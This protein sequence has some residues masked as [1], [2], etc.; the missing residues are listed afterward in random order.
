MFLK[1]L[2]NLRDI[3]L[4]H[5]PSE[6]LQSDIS[7]L[8]KFISFYVINHAFSLRKSTETSLYKFLNIDATMKICGCGNRSRNHNS[9][10]V[11]SLPDPLKIDSSGDLLNKHGCKSLLSELLIHA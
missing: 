7:G 1:E 5:F 6:S 11:H 8:G 10:C 2:V 4:L 3:F 9:R